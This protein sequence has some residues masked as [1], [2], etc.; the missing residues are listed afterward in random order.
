MKLAGRRDE[1]PERPQRN[2]GHAH[3]GDGDETERQQGDE[4]RAG[5]EADQ[6]GEAGKEYLLG[7]VRSPQP[8]V[9]G[10]Q[11]NGEGMHVCSST[12]QWPVVSGL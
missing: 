9:I 2:A 5:D 1:V 6:D 11:I 3:N 8:I 7:R 4:R 12:V 10:V